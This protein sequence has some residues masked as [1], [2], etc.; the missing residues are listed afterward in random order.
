MRLVRGPLG[1]WEVS[2]SKVTEVPS[3]PKPI[4]SFKPKHSP[5]P[6]VGLNTTHK[7]FQASNPKPISYPKPTQTSAVGSPITKPKAHLA[8]NPKPNLKPM[9]KWKP[10][11]HR[12][13]ST[14]FLTHPRSSLAS[15][16]HLFSSAS[17]FTGCEMTDAE[18]TLTRI[19]L[20]CTEKLLSV[21]DNSDA[22]VTESM[23]S[24]ASVDKSLCSDDEVASHRNIQ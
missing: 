17:S 4:D 10:K 19:E 5:A 13:S 11:L 2:W 16:T 18:P 6:P 23:S 8:S 15:P 22:S 21:L 1:A 24:D 9:Y 20:T 14:H 12:P 3:N 7:P